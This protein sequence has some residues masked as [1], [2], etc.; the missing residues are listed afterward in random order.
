MTRHVTLS[1]RTLLQG[2]GAST[3]LMLIAAACGDDTDSAGGDTD[4]TSSGGTGEVKEID[5]LTVAFPS[6][7]SNLY[8][9]KEAGI[10]NYYVAAL[11]L[12]G[13]V[14]PDGT[15]KLV[16]AVAESFEQTSP[17]TYVYTIRSDAKFSDGSAVTADD[18]VYSVG[19]SKDEN[20]SPNTAY[21]WANVQGAEKT[22]DNQVTITLASP[23]V[24]F[25]W[26]PCAANAMWITKQ[27]FVDANNGD[28]GTP[29]ALLLGTGP[30]KVTSFQ[31]DSGVELERVDT[32]WGGTAPVKTVKIQFIPEES[33]RLLAR[34]SGDIDIAVS[35][36]LDQ[37]EQW[38]GTE[39]TEV[40]F[41][42]DRSYVGIDFNTA[43][44]PF[45]DIHVRRAIGFACNRE[46]FVEKLL[47][48]HG[49]VAT[50]LTTPAQIESVLGADGA[51]EKLR[52]VIGDVTY[53]LAK[54]KDAL[55]QSK[56]PDG[57]SV[58]VGV[59]SS[60]PQV[61][62]AFQALAQDLATIGITVEV[63]E[64]PVEQWYDT[65]GSPDWGLAYMWYFNTTGDPAELSSWFLNEGNPASYANDEV[66]A[67]LAKAKEET[68]PA[69][70]IDLV[71][72]AQTTALAELPY[73]PLWWGEAAVAIADTYE[74]EDFGSY[75]LLSPWTPRIITKG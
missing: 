46:A 26:G 20:V 52:A 29:D 50:A 33:T 59:S 56:V 15:G 47:G 17:T 49:E 54:A 25:E 31:P 75:T 8:P 39:A 72:E 73:V 19:L 28:I 64:M 32:W 51:R 23:D 36:S 42:A 16:P 10:V 60:A 71:L 65:I 74:I 5:T 9:G 2:T 13:L 37:A 4:A 45:D 30:Y 41:A 38:A 14:A 68:D 27:S 7:M 21:Y 35:I 34:Q 6:S 58:K 3:L 63:E 67:T 44:E 43:V 53:D 40:L 62:S 69:K 66:A 61:S 57:F 55:A 12:E 48:G 22:G 24:A 70:R 18:I 1:R 11:V